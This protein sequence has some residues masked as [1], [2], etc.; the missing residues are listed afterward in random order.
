[1]KDYRTLLGWYQDWP[2]GS[3]PYKVWF[4]QND[5]KLDVGTE[6]S[7]HELFAYLLDKGQILDV[8]YDIP[9]R[10]WAVLALDRDGKWYRDTSFKLRHVLIR[11]L[12]NGHPE[13]DK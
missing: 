8:R 6:P 2:D 10:Q 1:V 5:R 11:I 13:G 4:D 7:D 12:R 3:A 9:G